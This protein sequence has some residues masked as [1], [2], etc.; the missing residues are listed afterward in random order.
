MKLVRHL[1]AGR[2]VLAHLLSLVVERNKLIDYL[3]KILRLA[4]DAEV[5][6]Y[7][8]HTQVG[9]GNLGEF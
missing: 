4:M 1:L 9:D 5:N 3:R 2:K 6:A 7:K 8:D